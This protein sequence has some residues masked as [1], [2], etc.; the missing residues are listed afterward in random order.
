MVPAACRKVDR[1]VGLQKGT[2]LNFLKGYVT[3]IAAVATL[4]MAVVGFING[5]IG[6]K[7]LIEA[8]LAFLALFGL[9]RAIGHGVD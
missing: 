2:T 4:L 6:I 8:V 1:A 9:R 3:Y 5:A 7:E